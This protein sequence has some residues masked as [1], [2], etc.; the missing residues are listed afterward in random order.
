MKPS[1]LAA[2]DV[3]SNAIRFLIS[4]VEELSPDKPVKKNAYLRIPFAL[5][6]M[7]SFTGPSLNKSRPPLWTP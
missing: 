4:N 5:G 3:G 7:F 6:R 1:M 2:I